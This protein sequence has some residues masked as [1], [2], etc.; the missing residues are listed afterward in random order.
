VVFSSLLI[1]LSLIGLWQAWGAFLQHAVVYSVWRV[2]PWMDPL[3]AAVACIL[4]L[5]F[6]LSLLIMAIKKRK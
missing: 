3:Q 5:A 4:A 1:L 2:A 6:G